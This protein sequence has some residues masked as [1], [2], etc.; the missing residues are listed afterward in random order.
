MLL[1]LVVYAQTR[2][3][4]LL[5]NQ[6]FEIQQSSPLHRQ[7]RGWKIRFFLGRGVGLKRVFLSLTQNFMNNKILKSIPVFLNFKQFDSLMLSHLL[8]YN[9]WKNNNHFLT[10]P[11]FLLKF[12]HDNFIIILERNKLTRLNKIRRLHQIGTK[13]QN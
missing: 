11:S 8:K 3:V 5:S 13:V 4:L 2:T 9:M 7:G 10:N 12:F 6:K 1:Q